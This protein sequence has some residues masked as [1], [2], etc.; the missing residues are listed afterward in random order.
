MNSYKFEV[1]YLISGGFGYMSE[2][3]IEY[4]LGDN[5]TEALVYLVTRLANMGKTVF[6]ITCR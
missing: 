6:S 3:K 2:S 1:T 4:S 5:S